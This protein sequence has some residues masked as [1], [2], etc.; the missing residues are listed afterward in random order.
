MPVKLT[1]DELRK[2]QAFL[3]LYERHQRLVIAYLKSDMDTVGKVEA[4]RSVYSNVST[5]ESARVMAHAYFQQNP[6]IAECL[7]VA[8]GLTPKE[9]FL[10]EV[11]RASQRKTR[12]T[13]LA[14]LKMY[15]ELQG[16]L[17]PAKSAKKSADKS[18]AAVIPDPRVRRPSRSL[19]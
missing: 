9:A 7:A 16:W 2:T 6:A 11:K 3:A 14:A 18:A 13:Q 1:L 12:P 10:A 4:I 17:V 8:A 19:E 5:F 15:A